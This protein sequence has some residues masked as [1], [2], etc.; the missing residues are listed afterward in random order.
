[1]LRRNHP[2][3]P[4]AVPPARVEPTTGDIEFV[5]GQTADWIRNADT[6]TGC[7]LLA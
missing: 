7:C 6:K 5:I 1:M 4:R 3:R 2:A